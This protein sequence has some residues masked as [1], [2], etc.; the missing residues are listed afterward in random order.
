MLT[1]PQQTP[2]RETTRVRLVRHAAFLCLVTSLACS[3]TT[4]A[5]DDNPGTIDPAED[6]SGVVAAIR[7]LSGSLVSSPAP[8]STAGAATPVLQAPAQNFAE[9]DQGGVFTLNL[10][11]TDAQGDVTKGVVTVAGAQNHI[12]LLLEPIASGS[13]S[14]DVALPITFPTSI[15][16]GVVELRASVVDAQGNVAAYVSVA[17]VIGAPIPGNTAT[18][19]VGRWRLVQEVNIGGAALGLDIIM[20]ADGSATDL[21]AT[22]GTWN[23][24]G[25]QLTFIGASY[26]I[27]AL[28]KT[29]LIINENGGRGRYGNLRRQSSP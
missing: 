10:R 2:R 17:V 8:A 25:D 6:P 21:N 20:E 12:D 16:P 13:G 3:D 23:A 28:N 15:R 4:G 26:T 5:S 11:F 19:I 14:F 18:L 24:S 27:V 9:I 22:T 1:V 7:L 29:S